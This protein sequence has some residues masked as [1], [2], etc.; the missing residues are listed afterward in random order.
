MDF[1]SSRPS[2][3]LASQLKDSNSQGNQRMRDFKSQ[4]LLNTLTRIGYAFASASAS[5]WGPLASSPSPSPYP[6]PGTSVL[7]SF[8]PS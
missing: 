2:V 1:I 3:H 4:N 7:T 5:A 6:A 8:C